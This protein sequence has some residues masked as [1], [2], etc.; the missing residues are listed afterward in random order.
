MQEYKERFAYI[1]ISVT[2]EIIGIVNKIYDSKIE[3]KKYYLINNE[4]SA[5]CQIVR[6]D[7]ISEIRF[8]TDDE[9]N[10]FLDKLKS[11]YNIIYY[12]EDKCFYQKLEE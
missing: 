6:Y 10:K 7:T 3:L 9:I 12:P 1:R 4:I 11:E 2:T 5:I 8:A